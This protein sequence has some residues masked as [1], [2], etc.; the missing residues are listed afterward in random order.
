MLRDINTENPI[1]WEIESE[2]KALIFFFCATIIFFYYFNF[3]Y[4]NK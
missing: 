4:V 3:M 2:P 1:F